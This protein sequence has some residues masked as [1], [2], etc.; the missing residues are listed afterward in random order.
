MNAGTVA[1]GL[2]VVG[3]GAYLMI[4]RRAASVAG[5]PDVA[6]VAAV[7]IAENG[8]R[9]SRRAHAMVAEVFRRNMDLSGA[10]A[11]DIVA[12]RGGPLAPWPTAERY[13]PLL[14]QA[15]TTIA[16]EAE[17]GRRAVEATRDAFARVVSRSGEIAP[18]ATNWTHGRAPFQP[19]IEKGY[20]VVA[21]EGVPSKTRPYLWTYRRPVPR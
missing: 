14:A 15:R 8:P 3:A 19:W 4:V 11:D 13:R 7:A 9:A 2:A 17:E 16:L 6:T 5:S 12:G 20:T 1:I 21:S 18:G 10:T